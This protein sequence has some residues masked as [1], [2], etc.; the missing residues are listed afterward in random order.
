MSMTP[1][2][3]VPPPEKQVRAVPVAEADARPTKM[4]RRTVELQAIGVFR[5]SCQSHVPIE[6]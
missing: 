3:D 4:A 1:T 6:T 2:W 5:L